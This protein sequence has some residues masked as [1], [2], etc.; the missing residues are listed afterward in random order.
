MA[1]NLHSQLPEAALHNPKGFSLTTAGKKL[2]KDETL[3]LNW[4]DDLSLPAAISFATATSAPPTE[5]TGDIYVLISGTP[6]GDWDGASENDWVRFDGSVWN[7]ITPV[8][9]T[10]CYNTASLSYNVFN[11]SAWA[12]VGGTALGNFAIYD[13]TGEPTFY[14]T[15]GAAISAAS[16]GDVVHVYTD[17]NETGAVE[18][19]LK[20]GVNING[21]GHTYTQSNAGAGIHAIKDNNVAV[22]CKILNWTVENTAGT[23][24]ALF[25]DNTSSKIDATG[26]FFKNGTNSTVICEGKIYNCEATNTSASFWTFLG[27][28][29]SSA[30]GSFYNCKALGTTKGFYRPVEAVNCVSIASGIALETNASSDKL[31]NFYAHST[32]GVAHY[33]G[34]CY[35]EGGFFV[36]DANHAFESVVTGGRINGGYYFSSANVTIEHYGSSKDIDINGATIRSTASQ[37]LVFSVN[38]TGKVSNCHIE[39]TAASTIYFDSGSTNLELY[40]CTVICL[41]NNAAGHT[42]QTNN[43]GVSGVIKGNVLEVANTSANCITGLSTTTLNYADNI[44]KGSPTT[45]I[46]ANIAQGITGTEDNY[47]NILI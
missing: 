43:T 11:G 47:G 38:A 1:V 15:I 7:A 32:G 40:N 31:I 37:A 25:I 6:H 17:Y 30:L 20:D 4:Q 26:S 5:V 29:G 23:G 39:S 16:S 22:T 36:S 45:P 27:T 46:N 14:S 35:V 33:G 12:T 44:Y 18:I 34:G 10:S 2:T 9:G 24:Y 13:S 28:N 21:N 42:I 8:T 3:S 19:T 41:Y